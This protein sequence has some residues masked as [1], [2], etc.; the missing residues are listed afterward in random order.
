MSPSGTSATATVQA[1]IGT[2]GFRRLFVDALALFRSAPGRF[3]SLAAFCA[4]GL[5]WAATFWPALRQAWWYQDDYACTL[6]PVGLATD[7]G[8]GEGRPFQG[9]WWQTFK[10][11]ATPS[12]ATANV[13]LRLLQ[14]LTHVGIATLLARALWEQLPNVW[15]CC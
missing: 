3:P 7:F 9:L 11:D 1:R 15:V 12:D 8:L 14:G 4:L 13:L 10:L 6:W 5:I 2:P